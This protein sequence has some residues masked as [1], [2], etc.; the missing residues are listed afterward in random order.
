MCQSYVLPEDIS[1]TDKEI[2][3]QIADYGDIE[4]RSH[5]E[6]K[7]YLLKNNFQTWRV[8]GWVSAKTLRKWD[9]I[10]KG[11]LWIIAKGLEWKYVYSL[12]RI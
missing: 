9:D 10:D 11:D 5:S 4:W 8:I 12:G 7:E 6:L 2:C 1:T 3:K